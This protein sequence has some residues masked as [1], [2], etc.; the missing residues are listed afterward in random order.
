MDRG[1]LPV[2]RSNALVAMRRL[3][4]LALL[5]AGAAAGAL[6]YSSVV[7]DREYRRLLVA[8]DEAL[9][10]D[11]AFPALEA[12]TGAITLRPDSML[13]HLKRAEAYRHRG[14]L[15]AALRDLRTATSLEPTAP[16]PL[17]LLGDVTLSLER[18]GRAAD[19]FE[20]CSA[21]DDRDARVLYKLAY[22][23]YRAGQAAAAIEPL[24]RAV[25]LTPD[26]AEAHHLLGMCLREGNRLDDAHES[27]QTAS[28][29]QPGLVPVR[30]ALA[31]IYASRGQD[32]RAIDELEA[33]VALDPDRP[34]RLVAVGLAQARAGRREAAVLA[35]GRA[36]ERFPEHAD[37]FAALGRVWL[38]TARTTGD[39]VALAKAL[40]ALHAAAARSDAGSDVLALL[41][42]AQLEDGDAAGA[43]RTLR[44]AVAR[45]PVAPEA[46]LALGTAAERQGRP[47]EAR[48]ALEQ[49]VA[50]AAGRGD[51]VELASHIARLAAA[52]GDP[53][54]AAYW[55]ERAV[56][57]GGPTAPLL[58]RLAEVQI[59]RG[60]LDDAR[61]AVT[62]GLELDPS[63]AHLRRLQAELPPP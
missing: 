48:H 4:L 19:A 43:E 45:L 50:V 36:A 3:V 63:S 42:R 16:R 21:L 17:E 39:P 47:E 44:Q 62:S 38:D 57:E 27:L 61:E 28:R 59:A 37:V 31:E 20:R 24:R 26:F 18:Y 32:A 60:R 22:A 23:R 30:E 52:L 1:A 55:L 56:E 35:L 34:E 13:A 8:G 5:V 11:Q 53:H 14:E 2:L 41:G 6:A 49:Y 40:E 25:A 46:F 9:A 7:A 33:L 58:A 10:A 15:Q 54:G 51:V 12:Y 29:L